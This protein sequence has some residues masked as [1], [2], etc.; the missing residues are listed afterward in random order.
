MTSLIEEEQ[1]LQKM[2]QFYEQT[3]PRSLYKFTMQYIQIVIEM[4]TYIRSVRTGDWKLRLKATE[5]LSKYYCAHDK[6]NYARMITLYTAGMDALSRSDLDIWDELMSGNWM[7]NKSKIPF[8]ALG[9]D[10]DLDQVD[11]SMKASGDLIGLTLYASA[12]TT[13]FP[14]ST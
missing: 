13:F 11:R 1:I 6:H 8:C 4:A 12:R 5:M 2:Y 3:T 10:H 7:D 14:D 9:A